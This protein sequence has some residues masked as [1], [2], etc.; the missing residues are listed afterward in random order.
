MFLPRIWQ[1]GCMKVNH[2]TFVFVV[3]V[4]WKC[5]GGGVVRNTAG[6]GGSR[7]ET[8]YPNFAPSFDALCPAADFTYTI[9][10]AWPGF[11][12][13]LLLVVHKIG[14]S[15]MGAIWR[16]CEFSRRQLSLVW[17]CWGKYVHMYFFMIFNVCVVCIGALFV[18]WGRFWRKWRF[19]N[20]QVHIAL[21]IFCAVA[22]LTK[23]ANY[24]QSM[25]FNLPVWFS[26]LSFWGR[27]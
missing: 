13:Y 23:N 6:S 2:V 1:F 26:R 27:S 22:I 7:L 15:R 20:G 3:N 8:D 5:L 4:F 18:A 10:F 14:Q 17:P 11:G 16:K 19:S 9:F 25:K 21:V 12:F 24:C